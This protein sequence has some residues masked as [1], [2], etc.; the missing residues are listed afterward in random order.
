MKIVKH[1]PAILLAILFG[2]FGIAYFLKLMP[3]PPMTGDPLTFMTLFS[4]TGYMNI[5]KALE[6]IGGLMLFLPRTRAMGLCIITPIAVNIL[7]FEVCIAKQ[8]GIGIACVLLCMLAIYFIKEKFA[9]IF[10]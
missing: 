6:V 5:I 2:V 10:N 4:S 9:G 1:I 3:T 8:P 7:L